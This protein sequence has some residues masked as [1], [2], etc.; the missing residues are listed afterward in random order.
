MDFGNI[1]LADITL[2]EDEDIIVV[3]K[4]AGLIVHGDGKST[5]LTLVDLILESHPEM[6]EVGEPIE[7]GQS[8]KMKG[9]NNELPPSTSHLQTILRPGIVH[10]LDK[11]TSGVLVIAKTQDSF[12][13]LKKAFQDRTTE[14]EY[15]AFVYGWPKEISQ[16]ITAPISRA[17]GDIRKWIVAKDGRGTEREAETRIE[18]KKKFSIK[19]SAD[20]TVPEILDAGST[21]KNDFAYLHLKPKTGRTHQLRVHLRSINH[22]ILC[23]SLYASAREPALGFMRLALHAHSLTIPR[24]DG[25]TKTFT[26]PFPEDFKE[27]LKLAHISE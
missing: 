13:F 6:K 22:P 10:R 23:D 21:E 9:E 11:D 25:T 26:A 15:R 5:E 2:Y 20:V 19:P 3:N 12:L 24:P 18:V 17:K 7:L 8:L 14:K 16:T 4:P 1:K 27:A